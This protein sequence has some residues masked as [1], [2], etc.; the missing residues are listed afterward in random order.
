MK[1]ISIGSDECPSYEEIIALFDKVPIT[2]IPAM[3]IQL[4]KAGYKRKVFAR[5]GASKIAAR[6]EVEIGENYL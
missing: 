3:L 2:Y 1:K 4:T 5:G 6:V